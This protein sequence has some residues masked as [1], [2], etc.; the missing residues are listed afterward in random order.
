MYEKLVDFFKIA[1]I[2][3]KGLFKFFEDLGL[4]VDKAYDLSKDIDDIGDELVKDGTIG[5][6]I[7]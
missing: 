5:K 6:Y 2:I 1:K 4:D 7:D 3:F